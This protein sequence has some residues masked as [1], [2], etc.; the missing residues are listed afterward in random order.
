VSLRRIAVTVVA[1]VTALPLVLAPG[2]LAEPRTLADIEAEL[3]RTRAARQELDARVA[4]ATAELERLRSRIAEL[5]V[6][7]GEL[8]DEVSDLR[9]EV[10]ELETSIAFRVRETF[11][12]GSSLDPLA[13]FLASDDPEGALLRAEVVGRVVGADRARSEALAAARERV[14]AAERRL[15][16]QAAALD[17]A[18]GRQADVAEQLQT[19]FASAVALE[20]ELTDE[21]RRERD[22]LERERLERER[23]EREEREREQREREARERR[24][25][26]A[27]ADRAQP[28][29]SSRAAGPTPSPSGSDAATSPAPAPAPSGGSACPLDQPRHFTDSWGAPRSGGRA[30]RGTD[31]MG[32]HGIPVRAIVS[33]TW[34][35]Q[36]PGANAGNWGILRGDDGNAYWYLHL[37]RHTVGSGARVA[38]GQQVATNGATGNAPPNAPHVHFEVHPGGGSAVNPYPLLRRVCG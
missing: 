1:L 11:K 8:A 35:I 4:A 20:A 26:D 6:E 10:E 5:E 16:E 9:A 30:H 29:A 27:A 32:P 18:R 34:L 25:R 3:E 31:I 13:V 33:G 28:P 2:A 37:E 12:F 36:A 17:A 7:R 15:A 22:R 19:D 38:A 24:A 14:A 21:A 23:R